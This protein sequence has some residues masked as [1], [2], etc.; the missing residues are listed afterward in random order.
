MQ[1]TILVVDD[2]PDI[3]LMLTDRLEA[4][5]YTTLA[6]DDGQLALELLE[7]EEPGLVLLDLQMP[8][9]TGMEVLEQLARQEPAIPANRP[10]IIVM[11]AYGTI[12]SAVEAMKCGAADFLTKPLNMDHL[13]LRIQQVLE[14]EGL[15]RHVTVL[16]EEVDSR[17]GTIVADTPAMA[18]LIGEIKQ[19]ADSDATVLLLGESGTGKELFA[20]SIHQWS[21]RVDKPFVV[22]NCVALTETLL[23]NE[24]F[25]HE[26]GAFTGATTQQKGKVEM[27]DEGT[28]FLDEIGD[29][30]P[31]L[32]AKLLRLLQDR[33]FHRVGGTRVVRVN[34][35]VLAATNRDLSR[36]VKKG[37]FR[38]D[39]FHRLN[40]IS[41]SIPPLRDRPDEIPHL[42]DLFLRRY[43]KEMGKPGMRLTEAALRTMQAYPWP[44]N[45]RE[46]ENAVVRAVVLCTNRE[47]GPEHLRLPRDNESQAQL[48]EDEPQVREASVLPY[49]QAMERYRHFLIEQALKRTHGNQTKAAETLG[50][51]RS[52]LAR[53]L[54]RKREAK[55]KGA[56]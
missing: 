7:F 51:Q 46:L 21:K 28:L 8:R 10:P 15:K 3:I 1:K 37:V 2:D 24:L 19:V 13:T 25:G 35:R 12:P 5:G 47:I 18:A 30:A 42:A 16:R 54:K 27:A 32:Q 11:T 34:L 9:M 29:M 48:Y 55:R 44:G 53:V 49:H 26:K 45:V 43:T 41:F 31:D 40:V 17:Y 4:L 36:A 39:L 50:L 38:E 20:R 52:Y 6:A 23:E 56:K 22:I 33:E 14:R